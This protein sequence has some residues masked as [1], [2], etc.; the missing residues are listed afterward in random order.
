[1]VATT[2]RAEEERR[3]DRSDRRETQTAFRVQPCCAEGLRDAV[4]VESL[5]SGTVTFLFSDVQ[6]S[7]RLLAELGPAGYERELSR[8]GLA[9]GSHA[10]R[11]LLTWWRP[12]HREL[13]TLKS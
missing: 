8:R 13:G 9:N 5:P 7:T 11:P 2:L 6:G 3:L 12:D 10:H 1:M 4:G